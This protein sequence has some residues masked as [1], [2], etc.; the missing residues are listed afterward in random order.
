MPTVLNLGNTDA[1][2]R[3]TNTLIKEGDNNNTSLGDGTGDLLGAMTKEMVVSLATIAGSGTGGDASE[4]TLDAFRTENATNLGTIDSSIDELSAKIT[5]GSE[6]T[7]TYAQQVG[8]YGK[9]DATNLW[10][11][12]T[13]KNTTNELKVIDE[14]LNTTLGNGDAKVKCM[15]IE[16]DGT[17]QQ[18][19]VSTAGRIECY[20]ANTNLSTEDNQTNGTQV[21]KIM[22]IDY[23]GNQNQART[24]IDGFLETINRVVRTEPVL[25]SISIPVNSWGYSDAIAM[26]VFKN[27]VVW[28]T[29]NTPYGVAGQTV[30]W[31]EASSSGVVNTWYKS[32]DFITVS[33]AETP[34]HNE[35][36][37]YHSF[38]NT[39]PYVRFARK[40][41]RSDATIEVW[42]INCC[43]S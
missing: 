34:N 24:N 21:S 27:L 11:S 41:T 14:T 18:I 33:M 29:I 5:K 40:N 1:L 39:A 3:M 2:I 15:G 12:L 6:D 19:K 20:V 17:Q 9:N 25:Q 32:S 4:A 28:G 36:E 37:F 42:D 31:V 26:N 35:L 7:L 13:T 22:G 8:L 23:L 43:K 10:H 30:I 38:T 16:D